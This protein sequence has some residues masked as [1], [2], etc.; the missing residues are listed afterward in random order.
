EG[1]RSARY[2][3]SDA[4][5]RFELEDVPPGRLQLEILHPST[6]PFRA[7]AVL[8]SP[9]QSADVGTIR[10]SAAARV[11]GRVID[12]RGQSVPGARVTARTRGTQAADDL[13]A[14]TDGDGAFSLPTAPGT[15]TLTASLPGHA[16]VRSVVTVRPDS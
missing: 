13:Y 1:R 14:V 16:D 10:L 5:G 7:P 9:G 4:A 15:V 3:V 8:V 11:E 12:E 6:V 2:A